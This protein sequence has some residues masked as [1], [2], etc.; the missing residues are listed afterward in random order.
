LSLQTDAEK[1]HLDRPDRHS[2]K[3]RS[4]NAEYPVP[5]N[6]NGRTPDALYAHEPSFA[7]GRVRGRHRIP[8]IHALARRSPDPGEARPRR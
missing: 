1:R 6:V 5:A 2:G 7:A 4:R 8:V 3:S